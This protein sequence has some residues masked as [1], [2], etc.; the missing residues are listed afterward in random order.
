MPGRRRTRR[1]SSKAS[2]RAARSGDLH[3]VILAGGA[4][5]GAVGN[6]VHRQ[7][8]RLGAIGHDYS[9][10]DAYE[11]FFRGDSYELMLVD[12]ARR[13]IGR[14]A[15]GFVAAGVRGAFCGVEVSDLPP[16][17]ASQLLARLLAG[18]LVETKIDVHEAARGTS[19]GGSWRGAA[20]RDRGRRR[21]HR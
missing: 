8:R 1:S 4:D 9:L 11:G 19:P 20:R 21:D 17:A 7:L 12:F 10:L 2:G 14:R 15:R 16:P 13:F 3:A 5:A 6:L 18:Y